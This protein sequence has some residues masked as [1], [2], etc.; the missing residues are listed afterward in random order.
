MKS[1]EGLGGVMRTWEVNLEACGFQERVL[2]RG[3]AYHLKALFRAGDWG[4]VRRVASRGK[5]HLVQ[6]Q[7]ITKFD[8]SPQMTPVNWVEATTVKANFALWVKNLPHRLQLISS[9]L[10]ILPF[11]GAHIHCSF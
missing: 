1:L 10:E 4:F 9:S 7:L 6:A 3:T 5:Q 11:I 2:E 8:G